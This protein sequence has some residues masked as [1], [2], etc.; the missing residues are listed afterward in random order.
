[1]NYPQV[2]SEEMKY[3]LKNTKMSKFKNTE[4]K[5]ESE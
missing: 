1:M 4:L 2:Y 5:S 3:K